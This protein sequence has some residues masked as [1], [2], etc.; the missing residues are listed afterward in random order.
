M[1][2]FLDH[3]VRLGSATHPYRPHTCPNIIFRFV[4][5]AFCC[6]C[7]VAQSCPTLSDPWPSCPSPSPRVCSNLC[8]LSQWWFLTISSSATPFIFCLQSFLASGP[9]P[10]CWLFTSAS[11]KYWSFSISPSSEFSGLISFRI[12]WFDLTVVQ[13][14]LKSLP[15]HH[16]LKASIL[17]HSAFFR[18]Q[19]LHLYT[20]IGKT[21][22]L[23]IW[24]FTGKVMSLL[25]N[26]L[27]RFVTAFLPRT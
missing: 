14:T 18:V 1:E 10:M 24:T 4:L 20:I 11:Q 19:L 7:S 27:S 12:D 23:T 22:A 15:Q 9:F 5:T 6:C 16:S 13:G 21:I 17:W 2:A 8:P 25:F 26:M 3:C